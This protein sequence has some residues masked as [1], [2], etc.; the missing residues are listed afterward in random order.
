MFQELKFQLSTAIL[1]LLTLASGVSAIIN[2]QQQARFRLPE[3]GVIWVDRSSGVEALH[4]AK[5]G[6]AARVGVRDGDI[7]ISINENPVH[8]VIDVPKILVRIGAQYKA[9]YVVRRSGVEVTIKQLVVGDAPRDPAV[10]YLYF[11]GVTY[12]VIGLFVYFRRSTAYKAQHFYIF[13]LVSFIFCT[14]HYT[15]K[16]NNFDKLMYWGNVTAGMLAPVIFV[17]FCLAFPEPRKWLRRRIAVVGF[18][19]LAAMM[20]ALYLVASSG[21]LRVSIPLVDLRWL[22]DRMWLGLLT[23]IYLLGGVAL[24]LEYRKAED[25]IVRRQLQWLRNGTFAGILPFA[26][27]YALPYLIGFIPTPLMKASVLALQLIPLSLAYAIVRYRL[28]DVDILFRRGYAY[29]LATLCVLAAFYGIIFTLA[30][31]VQ[32]NFQDLGNTGLV[33]IMLVAAFLFQPLRNWIQERLDRYFYRDQ[34][35]YRRTLVEF[36]RELSSET[37]L[38]TMLHAVADRLT[39]TL[40]IQHLAFFLREESEDGDAERFR[41]KMGVGLRDRNTR[42]IT[43][44]DPLDLSFLSWKRDQPY[45]FFERTRHRLDAMSGSWAPAVRR[46]I[47]DLDLTYYVPCVAHGSTVAYLGVSRTADGDFLSTVDVELLLTLSGYVAIAIENAR[48][49]SSLARKVEEY[50]RLKEFSE[51]IVESINVGILAAGLDD[52]VESWNTQIEQL[53][54]ISREQAVGQPLAALFPADLAEQFDMVRADTGVHHIYKYVLEPA[55]RAMAANGNGNGNGRGSAREATLNI[56]IAPLVSK[57]QEHIGRLIIFDDVTDRAELE[58]RL[59]QADKLSSIGLLAAGVA[60]EVNT[61]LAV[62]SSYAQMLA[63]Q[64]A[65]DDQK[66]RM[67]EKIAKS[68]FRASEI[69]NG[70]LNFSRT[71]STE[72]G[73]VNLNRVIQETISLVEHQMK[74]AGVEVRT[75]LEAELATVHGN[76]GKL[77][78]VFLNLFLN[79]R[80]AMEGGGVLEI[81]TA[82]A[83]SGACVE[84][85]DTGHGIAPEYLHRIYDPFFTTKAA[86][87]GTGLG[88]SVTYGIIQEHAG[89]I[90]VSSRPGGGTRFH[91]ELPWS[92]AAARMRDAQRK[93][94]NA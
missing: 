91:I 21:M 8:Q 60:H 92:K 39:Q 89:T 69:V 59:V 33:T 49:Y 65:E 75:A 6:P 29:T 76:A 46:T 74:K 56:A 32:K 48:L 34:Y 79:A 67:L 22:L 30:N 40:S 55:A 58:K 24:S 88:L 31:L 19:V 85:I 41:L 68:T 47:E 64:V 81:Q 72:F 13:C 87:K 37:D 80:D 70:L 12:L 17:H 14:F 38:G 93:P 44:E 51:N 94:V 71:S 25:P 9:T 73:E 26:L 52:R 1:T 35:D 18:Y 10:Y 4:V 50:E 86:R 45:L 3:D 84:V 27:F 7:L 53:T 16:L 82:A 77:Q 54:G 83:E 90:E 11:V 15:G 42:P 36:A 2:F 43:P 78:Q 57:H 63:K 61:P 28:M 66:S 62:I 5:G 20:I 23:V